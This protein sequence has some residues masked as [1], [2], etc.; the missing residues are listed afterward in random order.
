MRYTD[1]LAKSAHREIEQYEM[2]HKIYIYNTCTH[3]DYYYSYYSLLLVLFNVVCS[4]ITLY[5]LAVD[6][7]VGFAVVQ[8]VGFAV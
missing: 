6:Q 8:W 1:V 2:A 3:C 4:T 7:W 5:A